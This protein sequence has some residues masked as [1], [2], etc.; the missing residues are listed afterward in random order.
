MKL[1]YTYFSLICL[2]FSSLP[3]ALAQ[4]CGYSHVKNAEIERFT[5]GYVKNFDTKARPR[6]VVKIPVVVHILWYSVAEYIPDAQVRGQIDSLNKDFRKLNT[7][8][9]NIPTQRFRDLAADVEIEFCLASRDTLGNP[10]SGIIRKQTT[11]QNIGDRLSDVFYKSLGGDV[12]W[13]PEK[14][15]NIWVCAISDGQPIGYS[16]PLPIAMNKPAEDGCVI[17]SKAF[18]VSSNNYVGRNKGRTLV[19]EVGH[20]FNL[21]HIFGSDATCNDD[22][23][24]ADTPLQAGRNSMCPSFP[25]PQSCAGN[26]GDMYM[27]Y[28]D[29]PYDEC[30][31]MFTKGQKAR[32]WATLDGFRNGLILRGA[33]CDPFVSTNSVF[34]PHWSISPNPASSILTIQY[35]DEW[36]NQAKTIKLTDAVGRILLEKQENTEGGSL[37]LETVQNG[38]YFIS[39]SMDNQVFSK[40]IV[41]SN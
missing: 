34:E 21:L 6:T 32:M 7:D 9:S 30:V 11:I 1:F 2:S 17:S 35:P 3:Y 10:T 26:G 29:Y 37:S 41:V 36:K 39:I 5:E 18:G 23:E 22:D 12:A 15:L 28:M 20:Y 14:Y 31:L 16:T 8:A 4:E 38:L 24:V 25:A 33:T 40:K 27:N 13:R 19:H